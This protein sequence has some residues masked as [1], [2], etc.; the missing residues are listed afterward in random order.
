MWENGRL[1]R[2]TKKRQRCEIHYAS[3]RS[4]DNYK[5]GFVDYRGIEIWRC[6]QCTER[7]DKW[8]ANYEKQQKI[9][10][11]KAEQDSM[12]FWQKM[13]ERNRRYEEEMWDNFIE[14]QL[15]RGIKD[16]H[17]IEIPKELLQLKRA[18]M[19]LERLIICKRKKIK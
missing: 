6:I 2:V 19:K 5:F 16:S 14:R 10:K 8:L 9:K 4:W 12:K 13:R 7:S 15:L 11:E 18:S 17:K 3:G 1:F